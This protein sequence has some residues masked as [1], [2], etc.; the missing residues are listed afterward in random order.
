MAV[1]WTKLYLLCVRLCCGEKEGVMEGFPPKY[2]L[3]L[4]LDGWIR[5]YFYFF[6][7]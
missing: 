2:E 4:C 3:C 5:R 6:P 1:K 7:N